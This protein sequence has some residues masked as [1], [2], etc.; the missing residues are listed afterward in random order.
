[1]SNITNLSLQGME[2]NKIREHIYQYYFAATH[3]D[4]ANSIFVCLDET[5]HK[6]LLID[7]AYPKNAEPVKADLITMGY[8]PEIITLS[9][10]HPD[11]T[12]GCSV[13]PGC[14]IY[15]SKFYEDN[16]FNCS[17]W[18]P[19]YQYIHPTRLLADGDFLAFGSFQLSFIFAP[20]HSKCSMLTLIN[21]DLLHVGDLLMFNSEDKP[22]LPYISMGGSFKEHQTSLERIK[23][24][25]YNMTFNT[26][27]VPH[28]HV[29][30][31]KEVIAEQIDDRLFYL[32]KM[33]ATKGETP[34]TACLKNNLSCYANPEF[35]DNNLLQIMMET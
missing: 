14:P 13:F 10:F 2:K 15:A 22:T 5:R 3:N 7:T 6:A 9:H 11:H 27:L 17:R 26:L 23:H 19:R 21:N 32:E 4:G 28:G 30:N 35:H 18:E 8:Q 1:M 20:G 34:L 31:G 16:F 24:M 29:L 25:A 12:A 33:M